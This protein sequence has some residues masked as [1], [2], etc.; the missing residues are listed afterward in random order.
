MK[1]FGLLLLIV[2]MSSGALADSGT[3]D[4]TAKPEQA[5]VTSAKKSPADLF[6]SLTARADMDIFSCRMQAQTSLLRMSMGQYD[7]GASSALTKCVEAGQSNV[8]AQY[9]TLRAAIKDNKEAM[10]VV[11]DYVASLMA[12]F[13]DLQLRSGESNERRYAAR[14]E[15]AESELKK[16]GNLAKLQ[17]M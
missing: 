10:L 3:S 16:K 11:N 5:T 15:A 7:S 6:K 2:A 12:L 8:Q 4:A 1:M 14:I 13:D 9:A 17:L